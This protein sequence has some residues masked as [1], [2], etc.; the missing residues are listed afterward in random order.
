ML[1]S[2]F[3][4]SKAVALLVVLA[5]TLLV[6]CGDD[7][8]SG[9]SA[10]VRPLPSAG[11]DAKA[12]ELVPASVRRS[13]TL[14]VPMAATYPPNEFFADDDTTI[15][16]MG[17][18]M[19]RAVGQRLDLDT[20]LRS[21]PFDS[22]I[23]GLVD[24]KYSLSISS[25]TDTKEREELVDMVTYFEAGTG[26]FTRSDGP[27]EL[28]GIDDL[29]GKSVAVSIGTVQ[30]DDARAQSDKCESEGKAPVVVEVLPNQTAATEA[31]DV[32]VAELGMADTPVAAYIVKNSEG[33]LS[34][35]GEDFGVAPY[36][37]AVSKD[38]KLAPAVQAA[39]QSLIDD[40]TYERILKRWGLEKDAISRSR[41]NAA[42]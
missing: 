42:E 12:A 16:G 23:P 30:A 32:G 3:K 40:G 24:G 1:V 21:A 15:I 33:T 38:S 31:V 29:C 25:F 36:G 17:A 10:D 39:V 27:V 14:V 7:E 19:A 11:V 22:I 8:D 26:F 18:D 6:A 5:A 20:E 34:K 37:I 2:A 13:G 4:T 9:L 41:I 35:V 28:T